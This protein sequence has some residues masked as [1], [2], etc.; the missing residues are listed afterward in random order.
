MLLGQRQNT[1]D[2]AWHSELVDGHDRLGARPDLAASVLDIDVVR[3]RIDVDEDGRSAG[4]ADDVDGGDECQ[5][6]HEDVIAR[7]DTESFQDKKRAGRPGR[8]AN[9]MPCAAEHCEA[10]LESCQTRPADHPAAAEH[11]H[12]R[13]FFLGSE[14]RPAERNVCHAAPNLLSWGNVQ[15]SIFSSSRSEGSRWCLWNQS[16]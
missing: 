2:F 11:L 14:E 10:L 3:R 13:L 15:F 4:V 7:T 5:R 9:S 16:T 6:W 8:Y 12:D 1:I